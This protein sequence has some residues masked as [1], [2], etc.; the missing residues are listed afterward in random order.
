M[1]KR[2]ISTMVQVTPNEVE[3]QGFSVKA[4]VRPTI[5]AK[6][7]HHIVV[8]RAAHGSGCLGFR[9]FL[10]SYIY[11]KKGRSLM[12]IELCAGCKG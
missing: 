9:S 12:Y 6:R 3:G 2:V 7:C 10:E 11:Q 8:G 5:G 1:L 4:S